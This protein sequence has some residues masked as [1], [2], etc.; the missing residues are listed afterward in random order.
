MLDC[1]SLRTAA[2]RLADRYRALPHSRVRGAVA[3]AGL[4]LARWLAAEA[5][6]TEFP[7][8]EVLF[9]PD[10]GVFAVGDQIAVAAHDLAAALE[11]HPELAGKLAAAVAR[12]EGTAKSCGL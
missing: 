10:E 12:V 11:H 4:E 2:E 6:R 3:E 1:A 8:R 9:M 7:D 5:Q